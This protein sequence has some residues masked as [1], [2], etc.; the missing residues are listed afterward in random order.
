MWGI[1]KKLSKKLHLSMTFIGRL[2]QPIEI[3]KVAVFLASDDCSN[4]TGI[5]LFVDGG[6]GQILKKRL[7]NFILSINYK[8]QSQFVFFFCTNLFSNFAHI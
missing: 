6:T 3:S 1:Q 8:L 5:E 7:F 2:G 4:I